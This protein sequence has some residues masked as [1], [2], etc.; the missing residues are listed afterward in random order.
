VWV[1]N[2]FVGTLGVILNRGFDVAL[3]ELVINGGGIL[4]DD[5]CVYEGGCIVCT[6]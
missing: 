4:G 2:P 1:Q 3:T 6:L 5:C